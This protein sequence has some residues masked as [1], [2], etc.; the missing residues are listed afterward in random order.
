MKKIILHTI[1][2]VFKCKNIKNFSVFIIIMS[3]CL[4]FASINSAAKA[5]HEYQSAV[6]LLDYVVVEKQGIGNNDDEAKILDSNRLSLLTNFAE[7]KNSEPSKISCK[8]RDMHDMEMRIRTNEFY[9]MRD[10]ENEENNNCVEEEQKDLYEHDDGSAYYIGTE[11]YEN[12]AYGS[13]GRL[14]IPEMDFDV[15]LNWSEIENGGTSAQYYVDLWD[16]AAIYHYN[17]QDVIADHSHQGFD[18]IKYLEIGSKAYIETE[19]GAIDYV[20]VEKTTGHNT[21]H[22]IEL[23]DGRDCRNLNEGG[24]TMYTC[25][26]NWH[27]ITI[28]LWQPC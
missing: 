17:M 14:F 24:I 9:T 13:A 5:S 23:E 1:K 16:S 19:N 20:C 12:K 6:S 22:S 8:Y 25:N 10:N 3:F 15:A 7:F 26:E 2:N 21:G 18:V 4:C 28:L 27:N 11:Y